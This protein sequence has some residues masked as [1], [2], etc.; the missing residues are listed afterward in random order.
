MKKSHAKKRRVLYTFGFIV[1]VIILFL[2]GWFFA[3]S[4]EGEKPSISL[5]PL[6][7]FFTKI[8]EFNLVISDRKRGLKRLTI[9]V[10]QG[11]REINVLKKEFPFNGLLN[12]QGVH[13]YKKEIFIDP[14]VLNL[15]Q[16]RADLFVQVWDY[17]RRGGGDGNHSLIQHKMIVDTIPPAL[18]A[19]SRQ[20]NINMGGVGLIVYQTSSD[21]KESG[22][23]VDEHFS[24]G[25]PANK[26]SQEGIHVSYFAIPYNAPN[27]KIYLWAKDMAG[28]TSKT[29]FYVHVRKKKFRR[30]RLNI[31]DR[32]LERIDWEGNK[33][34]P[35]IW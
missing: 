35:N 18:R 6:P 32:F 15:A 9:S 24:P 34:V 2:V 20:H 30:E 17:S 27:P 28:N 10:K 31:S 3:I 8:Q 5:E 16:G 25:F 19:I 26:N 14:R 33:I 29:T 23:F 12:R 22:I 21:A 4:F 13:E 11:G 1:F 7:E